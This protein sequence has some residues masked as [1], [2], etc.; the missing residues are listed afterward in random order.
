MSFKLLLAMIGSTVLLAACSGGGSGGGGEEPGLPS[1]GGGASQKGNLVVTVTDPIGQPASAVRVTVYAL[2]AGGTYQ[3]FTNAAGLAEFNVP[4]G[5]LGV[6]AVAPEF[7]GGQPLVMLDKGKILNVGIATRPRAEPSAGGIAGSV[8]GPVS[9]DGRVLELALGFF[10]V[11]G[12]D[13]YDSFADRARTAR[14]EDCVPGAA[15]GVPG[16]PADCIVDP[17]GFAAGY[18]GAQASADPEPWLNQPSGQAGTFET[19]LLMDQGVDLANQDPADRRLFAAKYLLASKG[20]DSGGQQ[21]VLLGA[22]AADDASAGH[23]SPLPQKPLTLFPVENPGWTADGRGLFPLVD[24]LATLEG[25]A[26]A[27]LAAVDK[28][29]DFAAANPSSRTRG[30][31]VVSDGSDAACLSEGDCL[32]RLD[33]VIAESKALG[34]RT[35]TIGFVGSGTAAQQESMNLLA[36]SEPGGA[37]LWLDNPSQLGAAIADAQSVLADTKPAV[38]ATFRLE[39][40][41]PGAFASGRTVLG[42]VQF[43]DCPWDCYE[44]TV[45]FAVKIP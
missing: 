20:G 12:N 25:G 36:Q 17:A 9:A 34:V 45:P 32:Q 27:L 42:M 29:L 7:S 35:V 44:I 24:S 5:R 1:A 40:A 19:V 31:V 4:A 15:N 22:F 30:L 26:G 38:W 8:V 3:A 39:S 10:P 16:V 6:F 28:A 13:G 11:N 41:T 43:E 37:A 2:D 33:A 21:R 18:S 23:Y 14:V